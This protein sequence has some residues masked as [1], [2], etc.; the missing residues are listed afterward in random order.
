MCSTRFPA[1]ERVTSRY[2]H[3]YRPVC[4]VVQSF[5]HLSKR[6]HPSAGKLRCDVKSPRMLL[7]FFDQQLADAETAWSVGSFGAIAEFMRDADEATAIKRGNGGITA[8][9]ARGGLG[10]RLYPGLRLIASE[11]LSTESWSHRLALC[12]RREVCF[13]NA[14]TELTEI[15]PDTEVTLST[16]FDGVCPDF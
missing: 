3:V 1:K 6:L 5:L 14:R 11:C 9:T 2:F 15:G 7:E 10:I 16:V 13:M 4:C 8:V 12:L